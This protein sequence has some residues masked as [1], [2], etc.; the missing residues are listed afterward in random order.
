MKNALLNIK[1]V[2]RF[3]EINGMDVLEDCHIEVAETF[4]E[5]EFCTR[6]EAYRV[7]GYFQTFYPDLVEYCNK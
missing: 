3:F 7:M 6:E 4:A 2:R 1:R 5:Q